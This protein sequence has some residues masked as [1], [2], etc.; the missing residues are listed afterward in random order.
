M[1][2]PRVVF[3]NWGPRPEAD[4][5][6][7]FPGQSGFYLQNDGGP[8][9]EITLENFS[10]ASGRNVAGT[11]L[12]RIGPGESG[13]MFV[14]LQGYGPV[15]NPAKWDL[16]T[17]M[18]NARHPDLIEGPDP[19]VTVSI[20]Y[21]DGDGQK[22]RS[23]ATLT[24]IRS[25]RR[26]VFSSTSFES[27]VTEQAASAQDR[28]A[29][30]P[31]DEL[32]AIGLTVPI[33]EETASKLWVAL[34]QID[35]DVRR[36]HPE[37]PAEP[38]QAAYQAIATHIV[39]GETPDLV[40][41]EMI[42]RM[43]FSFA[44]MRPWSRY[45]K[46]EFLCSALESSIIAWKAT[47]MEISTAAG[48]GARATLPR[49]TDVEAATPMIRRFTGGAGSDE[50]GTSADDEGPPI[51]IT[52]ARPLVFLEFHGG[53]ELSLEKGGPQKAPAWLRHTETF[54]HGV[55]DG[56]IVV[57]EQ[58]TNQSDA[59][60]RP[61]PLPAFV[62][63]GPPDFWRSLR[64]GFRALIT[65]QRN[66][67]ITE[68]HERWLRGSCFYPPGYEDLSRCRVRTGIN[69]QIISD[70]QDIATQGAFKLGCPSG[71]DP[72]AFWL[73]CLARNLFE[74]DTRELRSEILGDPESGGIV[75]DLA[76][77]CIGFCSRL[78]AESERSARSQ[79]APHTES[80]QPENAPH[81]PIEP[82][83]DASGAEPATPIEEPAGS[84]KRWPDPSPDFASGQGRNDAVLGY[85]ASWGC[86]EASLART[87]R[88]D[89]ADL[90][91]WKKDRLPAGPGKRE[92]IENALRNNDSPKSLPERPKD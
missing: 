42:P 65:Q 55:R 8:A 57:H 36:K 10:V 84:A 73:Y 43:I 82:E 50:A 3:V 9:Y 69:G 77:S 70:F 46:L 5:T 17:A 72:V 74:S 38:V 85:T 39:N 86:P 89:A 20:R 47:R 12:N 52:M 1:E 6:P 23:T 34:L 79:P 18:V 24:L 67:G 48:P 28:A 80:N 27:I 41:E 64:S 49:R 90:S 2:R 87:A 4:P 83:V 14:N 22:F 51:D 63:S 35:A 16:P 92:R 54:K 31:L 11:P 78:A 44:S 62:N 61:E 45:G 60:P 53:R 88:V 71:T 29:L 32:R 7:H 33:D 66:L 15:P 56:S 37:L 91:K 75:H 81:R 26:P 40:L 21:R 58:A 59:P 13:F 76:G 68:T 30:S 25:Q 19:A